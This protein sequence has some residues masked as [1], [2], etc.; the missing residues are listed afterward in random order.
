M[1][2]ELNEKLVNVSESIETVFLKLTYLNLQYHRVVR[3]L[4][5]TKGELTSAIRELKACNVMVTES[6]ENLTQ[7]L[8]DATMVLDEGMK[9]TK[10][11]LAQMR[12][13]GNTVNMLMDANDKVE[14]CLDQLDDLT[15]MNRR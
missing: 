10:Q 12:R 9:I 7:P 1:K 4:E 6:D 13:Y 15:A 2:K 11:V 5:T 8:L 3:D 14:N